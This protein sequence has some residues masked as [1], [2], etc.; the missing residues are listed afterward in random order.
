VSNA[1]RVPSMLGRS[2][3]AAKSELERLGLAYEVR[4]I[5]TS[6]RSLVI[7]QTPGS[8]SR[9]APGSTVTLTSLL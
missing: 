7:A 8:G 1:V 3:E 9:V 5:V 6:D 4:Q 2:V